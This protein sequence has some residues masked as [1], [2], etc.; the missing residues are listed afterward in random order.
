MYL[1]TFPETKAKDDTTSRFGVR[2]TEINMLEDGVK[3]KFRLLRRRLSSAV[4]VSD[5]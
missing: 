5:F 4:G 2:I 3:L 1:L